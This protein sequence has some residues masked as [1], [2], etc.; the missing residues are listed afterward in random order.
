MEA[1][2]GEDTALLA[3]ADASGDAYV[4]SPWTSSEDAIA[5]VVPGAQP[6]GELRLALKVAKAGTYTLWARV[7]TL[8]EERA[9]ADSFFVRMDDGQEIDWHM[10]SA[11]SWTWGKVGKG[12]KQEPLTYELK[13]G[14]HQLTIKRREPGAQVDCVLLTSD[15]T[16]P[17]AL[18]ELRGQPLFAEAESG[19]VSAPMRVVRTP[20]QPTR[21]LVR[22]AASSPVV[23]KTDVCHTD[24]YHG[25]GAF[26]LLR[27]DTRAVN[28][29]FA[30]VLLP[31]PADSPT[32]KVGFATTPAGR[33]IRVSWPDHEDVVL[34]PDQP[35]QAPTLR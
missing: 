3:H 31:L 7:R 27:A 19:T 28:P 35:D 22:I 30:A 33:E 25:L 10:P 13:A 1:A 16:T 5:S 8:A 9:K 2:L 15:D 11:G 12:V 26:P 29:R 14:A 23:L 34:W 20:Q 6:P 24:D 32:P 21:M 17:P 4:D 18:S